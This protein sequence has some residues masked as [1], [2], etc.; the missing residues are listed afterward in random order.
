MLVQCALCASRTKGTYLRD[1]Y[2]KLKA[3]RGAKR[4]AIAI[5]H[6]ILISVYYML[7]EGVAYKELGEDYLDKRNRDKTVKYY[8]RQMERLGFEVLIAEKRAA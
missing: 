4:A 3:R 2:H 7:K 5:A 1:K 6:K 8:L